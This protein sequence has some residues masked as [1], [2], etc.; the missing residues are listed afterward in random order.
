MKAICFEKMPQIQTEND[1]KLKKFRLWMI[2]MQFLSIFGKTWWHKMLKTFN[3]ENFVV[4]EA[5]VKK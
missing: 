2:S 4:C 1:N 5:F 3:K